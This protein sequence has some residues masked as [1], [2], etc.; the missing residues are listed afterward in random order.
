MRP[1]T[2]WACWLTVGVIYG[3]AFL[4]AARLYLVNPIVRALESR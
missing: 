1:F 4:V 2:Y 3:A